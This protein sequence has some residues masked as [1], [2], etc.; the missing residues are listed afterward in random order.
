MEHWNDDGSCNRNYKTKNI[1]LFCFIEQLLESVATIL[2]IFCNIFLL[3]DSDTNYSKRW[4][5]SVQ[6]LAEAISRHHTAIWR[7]INASVHQA[8]TTPAE[9]KTHSLSVKKHY[10]SIGRRSSFSTTTSRDKCSCWCISLVRN[11]LLGEAG[12]LRVCSSI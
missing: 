1:K 9:I 7:A 6:L 8:G 5:C 12:F 4:R 3:K 11:Q 10:S 2:S